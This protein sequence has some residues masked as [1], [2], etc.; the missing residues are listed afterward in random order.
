MELWSA[1]LHIFH[2]LRVWTGA[3]FW[4]PV[5]QSEMSAHRITAPEE[6]LVWGVK[7]EFPYVSQ[8]Q[9]FLLFNNAD[10]HEIIANTEVKLTLFNL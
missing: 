9:S 7:S 4:L 6:S 8:F 10:H 2:W 5:S 3:E 1:E